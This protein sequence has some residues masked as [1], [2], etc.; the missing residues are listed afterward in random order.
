MPPGLRIFFFQPYTNQRIDLPDIRLGFPENFL[1]FHL[2]F[3][4]MCFSA[5]PTS[6]DCV[7]FGLLD[8]YE[9]AVHISFSRHGED[10]GQCYLIVLTKRG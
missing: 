3:N 7:V 4:R 9:K 2:S 8:M 5:P 1:S 10:S 6:P